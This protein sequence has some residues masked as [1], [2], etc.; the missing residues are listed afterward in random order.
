MVRLSQ[1]TNKTKQN[2]GAGDVAVWLKQYSACL[3][4]SS[5]PL[6]LQKKKY[7]TQSILFSK[8]SAKLMPTLGCNGHYFVWLK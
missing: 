2:T 7:I 8:I 1:K 3:T 5:I 4:M 6:V